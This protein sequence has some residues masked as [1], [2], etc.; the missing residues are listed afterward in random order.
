MNAS[1][2][3]LTLTT[4]EHFVDFIADFVMTLFDD[5]IE[6]DKTRIIIRSEQDLSRIQEAVATLVDS[7]D[8]A[9]VVDMTLEEKKNIDWIKQYQDSIQPI[10][11]GNFYIHPSWFE[12]KKEKINIQIDPALAFGSGHHATTFTCLESIAE[13]VKNGDR[14]IDVGC[15]SGIL[16]LACAKLGAKVDLCD[17]DPLSVESC[18]D[19]FALNGAHYEHLWEGSAAKAQGAYDVV[20]AN[21]IADVLRFIA[22]D[23]K[24]LVNPGGLV[25]LS[26]IL[27]TKEELVHP[28]FSDLVLIE[29]KQKDEWVTLI[30][31]KEING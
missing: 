13:R 31:Q 4:D 24:K 28:S 11:T 19:N 12:P 10:D 1:Y 7:L 30:Y 17:T 16:G 21:I 8:G 5:A 25:I 3:E 23:L 14:I 26:G 18:K 22:L 27:D 6:I 20:I 9:I 15:G 2:R 29:K